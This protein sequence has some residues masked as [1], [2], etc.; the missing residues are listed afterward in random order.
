M[1]EDDE[2]DKGLRVVGILLHGF[3]QRL[4]RLSILA[5]ATTM[6]DN[7]QIRDKSGIR[8]LIVRSVLK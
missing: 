7:H 5:L 4:L 8:F 1:G 2:I 6:S 3:L